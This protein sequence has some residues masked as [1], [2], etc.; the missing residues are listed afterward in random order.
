[1]IALKILDLC[2]YIFPFFLLW[3]IYSI[4]TA[5]QNQNRSVGDIE[6]AV[7]RI[8]SVITVMTVICTA[9]SIGVFLLG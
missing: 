2:T 7:K 5:P 3:K 6:P 8:L 4:F 1:M 9:L